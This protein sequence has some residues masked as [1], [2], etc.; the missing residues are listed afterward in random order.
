GL[1]SW[2]LGIPGMELTTLEMGHFNGYPLRVDPGSTRGGEFVWA[3]QPPQKLF[4]QLRALAVDPAKGIVQVNHPRQ[5]VLGYFAQFFVDSA[6]AL[7]YTPAGILGV[8]APYGDEFQADKVSYDFDAIELL[9]GNRIE[10]VHDFRA[11]SP[12]PPGPFPNPQPVPGQIVVGTDGRPKFPGVVET[13]FTMLD[14]GH[15][16]TGVG[17][18]DSHQ[19]LGDEPGY[20]RTLLF[21]G[22]GKDIPGG[23][24]RDD[25]TEAI[26][27]HHAITTN[28][29]FLEMTIND[30]IIGD[31]TIV[32]GGQ[33]EIKIRVQAPSWAQVDRMLLYSNA[34]AILATIPI[35][36]GQGEDFETIQR[37]SIA[38]D[39]WFVAE[40]FGTQNMFPVVSP[41]EYPPLDATVIITA[42]SAGFDLSSLPIA[43]NLRPSL[44]HPTRPYAI[45]NPI[46]VDIDG[47]GWTPPRGALP[48]T[49]G[50]PQPR[51]DVRS[52]FEALPEFTP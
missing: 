4:D 21:V 38:R 50:S 32:Q 36:A 6:T 7:P 13:W 40:V 26:R 18:S 5:A 11:P 44:V 33:V 17:T 20:A 23:Y 19:L 29:P 2:L 12:L 41:V 3:K 49:A 9:T 16:A 47:N 34:G 1:E 28:A 35:P 14:R 22:V 51:P 30:A 46:W 45:T 27:A 31:T 10:D 52:Q 25:V 42:L 43:S 48:R 8:F 15:K 39:S 37:V 24:S